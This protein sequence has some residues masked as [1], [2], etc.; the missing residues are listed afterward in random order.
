[1]VITERS[2][3]SRLKE[4]ALLVDPLKRKNIEYRLIGGE[5]HIYLHGSVPMTSEAEKTADVVMRIHK[6]GRREVLKNRDG[7][8]SYPWLPR[9]GTEWAYSEEFKDQLIVQDVLDE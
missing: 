9:R 6:D 8:L 7:S 2:L 4:I 1:M 5:L 3:E